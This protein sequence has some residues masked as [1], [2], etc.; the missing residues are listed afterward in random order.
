MGRKLDLIFQNCLIPWGNP[1]TPFG[2]GVGG[3]GGGNT[4][5]CMTRS[6]FSR[7]A[8]FVRNK[9]SVLDLV[10]LILVGSS[11]IWQRKASLAMVSSCWHYNYCFAGTC[12]I[13]KW[14][15]MIFHLI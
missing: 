10:S 1:A 15:S 12:I 3:G 2:V 6:W 7:V 14:F 5:R 11:T 4:D 9:S 8:L 13:L